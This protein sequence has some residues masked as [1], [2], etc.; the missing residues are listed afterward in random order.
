MSASKTYAF[1][2]RNDDTNLIVFQDCKD[3]VD[4]LYFS[5]EYDDGLCVQLSECIEFVESD[6]SENTSGNVSV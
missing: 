6:P 1:D 2:I 3:N 5:F 4:C